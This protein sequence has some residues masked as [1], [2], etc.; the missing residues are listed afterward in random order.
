[1]AVH[2]LS[3][4][5]LKIPNLAKKKKNSNVFQ[6]PSLFKNRVAVPEVC[7]ET[8]VPEPGGG[9]TQEHGLFWNAPRPGGDTGL[10]VFLVK[11]LPPCSNVKLCTDI[12]PS[13]GPRAAIYPPRISSSPGSRGPTNTFVLLLSLLQH[14]TKSGGEQMAT[15]RT[16]AAEHSG[17][18]GLLPTG[19]LTPAFRKGERNRDANLRFEKV[20][21]VFWNQQLKMKIYC[22]K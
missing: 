10:Q 3:K 4:S 21:N 13:S 15:P 2:V 6:H 16:D 18:T 12:S 22:G 20:K 19:T 14:K 17:N 9:R 1:M 8:E 5:L 7:G 11:L